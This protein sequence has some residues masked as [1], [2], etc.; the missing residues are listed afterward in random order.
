MRSDGKLAFL[1][2]AF[3]FSAVPDL[4]YLNLKTEFRRYRF[5]IERMN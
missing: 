5:E 2:R 1:G 3:T 4:S